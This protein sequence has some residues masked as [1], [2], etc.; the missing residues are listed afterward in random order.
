MSDSS[1]NKA[2]MKVL[3]QYRHFVAFIVDGFPENQ[4]K[5]TND[6]ADLTMTHWGAS[7]PEDVI[8]FNKRSYNN[9]KFMH[10]FSDSN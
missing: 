8:E 3:L 9:V 7:T 2:I 5:F 4:S 6:V 1:Y 10:K